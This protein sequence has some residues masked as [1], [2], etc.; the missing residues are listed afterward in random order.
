M[1]EHEW[2]NKKGDDLARL[3]TTEKDYLIPERRKE[4]EN[5]ALSIGT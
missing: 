1:Y 4:L 3:S 2:K 5:Q